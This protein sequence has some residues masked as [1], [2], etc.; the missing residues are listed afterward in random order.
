MI[1]SP[2]HKPC[3]TEE[4]PI[5]LCKSVKWNAWNILCIW[6][7]TYTKP[8][9]LVN[10]PLI[11]AL[12]SCTQTYICRLCWCSSHEVEVRNHKLPSFVIGA[13]V[14]QPK[15]WLKR[16]LPPAQFRDHSIINY[17]EILSKF[18]WTSRINTGV[19]AQISNRPT[20]LARLFN[21]S[22]KDTPLDK[23]LPDA[24]CKKWWDALCR[25]QMPLMSVQA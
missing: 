20:R 18:G 3:L 21:D 25:R 4:A 11:L 13:A 17:D 2:K 7:Q 14:L 24:K 1:E 19:D 9:S 12:L 15:G 6:G 23:N 10:V 8:A 16:P 5:A 22:L